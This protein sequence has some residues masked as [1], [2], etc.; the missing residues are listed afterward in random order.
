[1]GNRQM[2]DRIGFVGGRCRL[3]EPH[4]MHDG[5]RERRVARLLRAARRLLHAIAA[6]APAAARTGL[7]QPDERSGHMVVGLRRTSRC[8]R[9]GSHRDE[10]ERN[11]HRV[12]DE[13][14]DK[15]R[16]PARPRLSHSIRTFARAVRSLARFLL[17]FSKAIS[18]ELRMRHSIAAGL[19]V[20]S[21]VAAGAQTSSQPPTATS[22]Q[23]AGNQ[24]KVSG[25][26]AAGPVRDT[27]TLTTVEADLKPNPVGTS[28]VAGLPEG[29]VPKPDVKTVIYTLMP[30]PGVNLSSHIG[31]TVEVTGIEPP[32][33]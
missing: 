22:S 4:W 2:L 19:I 3:L 24:A 17:Q 8:A 14:D 31:H 15:R 13:R 12:P 28:G 33:K 16:H 6:S 21:T 25:C 27:F 9:S 10:H 23:S 29:G 18:G 7:A 1:R 5:D 20:A 11:R 32:E 26:L 30:Q